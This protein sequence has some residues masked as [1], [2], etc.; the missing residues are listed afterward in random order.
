M[1]ELLA[2]WWDVPLYNYIVH[3]VP[4]SPALFQASEEWHNHTTS[5][6]YYNVWEIIIYNGLGYNIYGKLSYHVTWII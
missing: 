3:V 4:V 5:F 6:I 1:P 2:T